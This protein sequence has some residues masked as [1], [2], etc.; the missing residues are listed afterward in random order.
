[1]RS[2][3]DVDCVIEIANRLGYYGIEEELRKLGF[4]N[5]VEGPTCR[6]KKN[7]LILDVMPTDPSILGFTNIWY[8]EGVRT[9][10]KIELPS[11]KKVSIFTLPYF[12]A[13]KIEAFKGRGLNHFLLSHDIEDIIAV[14]DGNENVADE[15]LNATDTIKS[16]LKDE[17]SKLMKNSDFTESI[18][19]H[20]SDR[21]NTGPRSRI[22]SSR[23]HKFMDK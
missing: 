2:T 18:E 15:I 11:G 17:F 16:Y 8:P 10:K 9:A 7:S 23:I 3:I 22:V 13:S 1:M 14:I 21:Q 4:S 6:W 19:G 12:I 20:I 5:V